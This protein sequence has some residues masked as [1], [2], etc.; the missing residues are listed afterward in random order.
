MDANKI[1]DTLIKFRDDRDWTKFHTLKN[2][3]CAFNVEAGEMLEIVQ[4]QS[5]PALN[6]YDKMRFE[7]ADCFIY[8]FN[9][10]IYFGMNGKDIEQLIYRKI[11]MNAEK[12][13]VGTEGEK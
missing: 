1:L 11:E 2:L 9:I 6:D 5:R 4:W 8:L 7:I 12:Y 3:I 10:C 13:P